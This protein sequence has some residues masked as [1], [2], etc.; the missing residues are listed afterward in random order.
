MV[1]R[2][3]SLGLAAGLMAGPALGK[4][5]D[6]GAEALKDTRAMFGA[7]ARMRGVSPQSLGMWWYAGTVFAERAGEVQEPILGVEGFSFNRIA[8]LPDGRLSQVLAEAGYFKDLV[9]GA[10]AMEWINPLNRQACKPQ[11]YRLVQRIVASADSI[12]LTDTNMQPVDTRGR[13][14]P[15]LI[16]GDQVW[17]AENFSNK[18]AIPRRDGADPATYPGPTLVATSL[19]T[20]SARLSDV[21]DPKLAFVPTLL[22]YQSTSG[23][24]PWMRMGREPGLINWQLMGRKLR[25]A[26]EMPAALRARFDQDH[27]GWVDNPGI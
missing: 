19:A 27:P 23:F 17:I 12:A 9:T 16:S 24:M 26:A 8:V 22:A 6:A 4:S 11:H 15:A 25:S 3:A 7:Y 18:Y 10:I 2:R 20:F 14:G 13:I 5:P 21:R 1:T